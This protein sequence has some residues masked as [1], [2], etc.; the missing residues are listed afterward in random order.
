MTGIEV[1]VDSRDYAMQLD[2]RFIQRTPSGDYVGQVKDGRVEYV[3]FPP[4]PQEVAPTFSFH[5]KEMEAL[6]AALAPFRK[7]EVSV[8]ALDDAR[9][10]RDRLLSLVE[11]RWLS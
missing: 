9:E 4:F 2:V 7:R 5:H 11:A 3:P 8:E 6:A 1:Y 10:V